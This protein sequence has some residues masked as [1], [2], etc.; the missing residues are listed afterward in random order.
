[1]DIFHYRCVFCEN[2]VGDWVEGDDPMTEH[3]NLFPMCPFVHE[4]GEVPLPKLIVTT[5]KLM[6]SI[7]E[8]I[9]NKALSESASVHQSSYAVGWELLFR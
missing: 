2:C 5:P 1:M 6:I 4:L 9:A 3:R 7:W 8:S